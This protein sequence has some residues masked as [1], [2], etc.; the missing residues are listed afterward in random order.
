M[1]KRY[2]DACSGN[3]DMAVGM[4]MENNAF[5]P[6][7][8]AVAVETKSVAD[9]GRPKPVLGPKSYKEM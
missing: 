1:A 4:H 6:P 5:P 7:S 3:V 9:N 8:G 2:L